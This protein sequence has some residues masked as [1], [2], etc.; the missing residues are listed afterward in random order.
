MK[1]IRSEGDVPR[2]RKVAWVVSALV[3]TAS[4]ALAAYVTMLAL[5]VV[6]VLSFF[7]GP[8]AIPSDLVQDAAALTAG[9]SG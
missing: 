9:R 2:R 4:T 3:V 5:N 8:A 1:K 6:I 7:G